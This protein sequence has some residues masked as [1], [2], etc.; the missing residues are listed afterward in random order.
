MSGFGITAAALKEYCCGGTLADDRHVL[1]TFHLI[2]ILEPYQ[3]KFFYRRLLNWLVRF[4][5]STGTFLCW[6][7]LIDDKVSL[8]AELAR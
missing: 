8:L 2:A 6:R 4:S 5:T 7:L 3:D 1:L